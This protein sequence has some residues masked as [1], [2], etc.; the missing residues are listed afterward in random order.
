MGD[1]G[2]EEIMRVY[3][4]FN[5]QAPEGAPPAVQARESAIATR[6]QTSPTAGSCDEHMF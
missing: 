3:E 4:Q 6:R 5:G 1:V 2:E